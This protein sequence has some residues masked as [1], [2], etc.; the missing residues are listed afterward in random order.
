MSAAA[1]SDFGKD[2]FSGKR[3]SWATE[4]RAMIDR[5]GVKT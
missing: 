5:D 4:L 1:M 2:G 3:R